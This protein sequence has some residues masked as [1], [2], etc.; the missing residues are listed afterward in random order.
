MRTSLY[1]ILCIA[2]RLGAVFLALGSLAS[3]LS[4]VITAQSIALDELWLAG[5]SLLLTLVIAFLLWLFPGPLARMAAARSSQQVFE[6]P[7]SA[8]Q[9]QWIALSVLG[10]YFVITGLIGFARYEMQQLLA[11]AIIDRE[12]H[13]A[14]FIRIGLYCLLQV[15]FGIALTLGARGLVGVLHRLRY[16][17]STSQPE[18]PDNADA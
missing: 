4:F 16:G 3:V 14:D 15:G 6:S 17:A 11:D 7:I 8:M 9:I 10:M 13:L 18:A 5:L 1:S 12:R 2:I